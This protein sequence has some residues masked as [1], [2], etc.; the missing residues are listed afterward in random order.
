M[1]NSQYNYRILIVEDD[2]ASQQII[3]EKLE[4][5]YRLTIAANKAEAMQKLQTQPFEILLLDIGLPDGSGLDIC[6]EVKANHDLYG[7]LNII[8]ITG[9]DKPSD[10]IE[11]LKL[12]AS[13]YISKPINVSVLKARVDLQAQLIRK[14]E[15]LANLARIDG[16]TEISNRRAFNDYLEKSWSHARRISAPISLALIDIDFFKQY[17]DIYGHPAGD[18]CLKS[19][20]DCLQSNIKRGSDFVARYGG[21][22]FAVI[23]FD[24]DLEQATKIMQGLLQDFAAL[25]IPHAASAVADYATFS[26]GLCTA[27]PV[28]QAAD[29]L[30]KMTDKLLYRAKSEGRN[31]IVGEYF[32]KLE[33]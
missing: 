1:P 25:A 21:E 29:T 4:E 10:E 9:K 15:L 2:A 3:A 12:G 24:C 17:N 18:E 8:F 27:F 23:L 20:A 14:T 7:D 11:G 19:M 26:S 31:R 28:D 32:H 5:N 6:R 33:G 13:D 30:V 22:E 16:L